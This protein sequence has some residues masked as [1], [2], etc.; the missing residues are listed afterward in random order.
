M[1]NCMSLL[2]LCDNP[3]S[4]QETGRKIK[5]KLYKNMEKSGKESPERGNQKIHIL[6]L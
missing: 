6:I 4:S 3:L 5:K 1:L 2:L